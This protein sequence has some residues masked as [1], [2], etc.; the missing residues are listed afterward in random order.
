MYGAGGRKVAPASSL[1]PAWGVY[2]FIGLTIFLSALTAAQSQLSYSELCGYTWDAVD[3]DKNVH[4]K[5]SICSSLP[6]EECGGTS[7]ICAYNTTS[8]SRH[9]IG[10]FSLR[11]ISSSFIVFNTSEICTSSDQQQKVQTSINFLCGKTLGSP[12]FVTESEC[13]YYFEWRSFIACR[14]DTFKPTMEVPCYAFDTS[15]KKHDLNPLIKISGAYLVDDSNSDVD[16]YINVCRTIGKL[17]NVACPT[18]S[19][20]CLTKGNKVFNIGKPNDRLKITAENRLVLTYTLNDTG[21]VPKPDFCGQHTPA[22]TITFTCPSK[23]QE[24]SDPKLTADTNCRYEI[25]WITEF[26]C[27][28]DYLESNNCSLTSEQ[29]DFSVD[30]SPLTLK[31]ADKPYLVKANDG[32]SAD[33]YYYYLN[34]CGETA[35]GECSDAKGFIS[36]CQ[37]KATGNLK[38]AAGRYKNQTLRYSD[39]DLTLTY[40]GGSTCSSGFQRMT[41]INFDCNETAVDDGKGVPEFVGEVDCTYFFK[42]DTKYA[43]VYEKD[44]CIVTDERKHYDLSTLT[45]YSESDRDRNWEAVDSNPMISERKNFYINVCNKVLQK[46]GALG[47]PDYAAVC[48]VDAVNKK[49]NLGRFLSS[50]KKS[51]ANIQL[52]YSGG[53]DCGNGKKIQSVITLVCRP[54]D[55]ESAPLFTSTSYDQCLY[56]FEWHTAAACV[57]SKTEGD[58]CRVSDAQAGFSFD[59][60]PLKRKDEYYKINTTDY[61][62]YINVCGNVSETHCEKDSAICQ[63]S[64]SSPGGIWNLGRP[65]SRLAYHDGMIQIKYQNGTPYN[66]QQHTPRSS[67]ITFLCDWDAGIGFPEYQVEDNRT[68]N[69]RWYTSY[70]CPEIPIECMVTDSKT[71]KQYDL[72]SLSKS[73]E[74]EGENWVVMDSSNSPNLKKYYINVCRPLNPILECDKRASVCQAKYIPVD[75]DGPKF[76]ENQECLVTFL[77]NTKAACPIT[78]VEDRNQTCSIRD[79]DSGFLYNLNALTSEKGYVVTGNGV[80]FKLNICGYVKECGT[81][82]QKFA[83]CEIENNEPTRQVGVERSLTLSTDGE[84]TL[85]YRGAL[86]PQYGT[87]NSFTVHFVCDTDL[88]PGELKFVREEISSVSKIHDAFFDFSTSLVCAPAPVDCQVTDSSGNEYDLSALSKESEAWVAVDT[89]KDAGKR[90]FFLN[91]CRPLPSVTAC[92]GGAIGS[93]VKYADKSQNLGYIQMSPQAAPDGSLSIVYL[94]GDK[95]NGSHYS[96][97]IIFQ[98]DRNP[99]SPV[100]Q[101]Q[102][103]CEFVFTW[104]TPEACPIHRAEGD[105][106]TVKHPMFDFVYDLRPLSNQAVEVSTEEYE[107]H[108][109]VCGK[110]ENT[111]CISNPNQRPVAS[112]QVKKIANTAKI[113]GLYTQNLTYE[114]GVIKMNL[115]GGEKCHNVYSRSTAVF[116]FCDHR[117]HQDPKFLKETAECTYVFEWRTPYACLPF[118]LFE[119]S[120]RDADGNAYDLSQLSRYQ[121]NWEAERLA[122]GIPRYYINICKPLVPQTGHWACPPT[123]AACQMNGSSFTSLGEAYQAPEWKN[124]TLILKY[125]NGDACPDKIRR[126]TTV[127]HFKCDK[128][129]TDTNPVLTSAIEDC[130]YSFFWYTAAACPLKSS[131]HGDC[132]VANPVTG[133]MFDLNPLRKNKWHVRNSKS[134]VKINVC[135]S[136]NS[137][138]CKEESGVCIISNGNAINAGKFTTQLVYTDQVLQLVYADGDPCEGNSNLRHKSIISFVCNPD[139][140]D[141]NPV[142]VSSD[143]KTCTHYFSWHTSLACEKQVKCSVRNG[144][145]VIDLSPLVR[146]TSYYTADDEEMSDKTPDFYI[147]ICQPLN[148]IPGVVCPPGSFVCMDPVDGLPISIGRSSEPPQINSAIQEVYISFNSTTQCSENKAV[149]YSSLV[150]FHCNK[151]TDLGRPKMLRQSSCSY[152]FEWATP[153]VCSDLE[154]TSGCSLTDEQLHYTFNLSA[155]TGGQYQVS[156][157]TGSYHINV[158]GKVTDVKEGCKDAGV[159]LVSESSK[160]S[161]GSFKAMTLSYIHQED[162]VVLKYGGGDQCPPVTDKGELCVLPFIFQSKTYTQCT[163]DGRTDGRLWCATTANYDKDKKEGFCGS[164]TGYRGSTIIFKCD[165]KAGNGNPQL[166]SETYGC[167]STFEWKTKVV[168]PPKKMNCKFVSKHKTYDLRMLSSLTGSWIFS[169]DK[170]SYYINLCQSVHS[171]PTGCRSTASICRNRNGKTDVLGLIHTQTITTQGDKI[172]ITYSGGDKVCQNGREAKTVM[173]LSCSTTVGVP[174]LHH[175]DTLNCTFYIAWETRAACAVKPQKVQMVNGTITIPATQKALSL[176]EV[177]SKLSQASGDIRPNGDIYVYDIQLSGITNTKGICKSASVCQVKD[178]KIFTRNV[179]SSNDVAYYILDDD[180]DVEFS[181]GSQCGRDKTKTT[182]STIFFR[183]SQSVGVG[184]PEFIHETDDCQYLFSWYTDVICPL[185]P[186]FIGKDDKLPGEEGLSGRSQAV[187]AVL[188]LL[189]V[190]LTVCLAILLLYKQ[191][192]RE[193]VL[194]KISSCCRRSP[195]VSYKYSK[196]NTEED[197]ENETDWLM[198]D[199]TSPGAQPGKE[200]QENGHMTTKPVNSELLSSFQLDEQDSEDELLTVPDVKIN[201]A[202]KQDVR[203]TNKKSTQKKSPQ[204]GNEDITSLLNGERQKKGKLPNRQQKMH[205]KVNVASFHDDSDEDMLNL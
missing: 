176:G 128:T 105:N 161:Y 129:K 9:S 19:A 28:R 66:N 49:I 30:L 29:H 13:V 96:T 150:V 137:T 68:Y 147:S 92:P 11:S 42:W 187:G 94:N 195:H 20:A 5:L 46:G 39:G 205:N 110:L 115:T 166:L 184:K 108:F 26:A 58:N 22:V 40:P 165:E 180:L 169:Y 121:D 47:C 112:C 170:Y 36:S 122:S 2:R 164:S 194:H 6:D 27:Q 87:S 38:K 84:V 52:V 50:P 71:K 103:A 59:L 100:F 72:S 202:K 54:G 60:S 67:L 155:L 101:A 160:S 81:G 12:E 141:T 91:V 33:E 192:R 77:W 106:C 120:V 116:F 148:P 198:E 35:A 43:C 189:L 24:G 163:T 93:C 18:G 79:P 114:N 41:V 25:D 1:V 76:I 74:N 152:V 61:D 70:A 151:G 124:G 157:A 159:C 63:V 191:E 135:D 133:H 175:I 127:I 32:E 62:F 23:R 167:S 185:I 132:R 156:S 143:E 3:T 126:K 123:A 78:T 153:V 199:I 197:G 134:L 90:T 10:D 181:S 73:E 89:S 177:Y 8:K 48:A 149:N 178:D 179:G 171:G 117:A 14:K 139:S 31:P 190:V 64:K 4:Y 125:Q 154:S 69:F 104:S 113:A 142:L 37:V 15:G 102:E 95:C 119:C 203:S 111:S 182:S 188:S 17:D 183:C 83:G 130:E 174:A 158:C 80:T 51:G 88:Y 82:E 86:N 57:L 65:S 173:Q 34:V 138:F 146:K 118:K 193:Y 21:S 7:A 85:T 196:I 55:L 144:T 162:A 107:Y 98:C 200:G 44:A 201:S 145:S 56:E 140:T 136:V 53:D 186:E 97:R 109:S 75:V 172:L 168:C 131:V 16:L 45:R 204:S 99:G